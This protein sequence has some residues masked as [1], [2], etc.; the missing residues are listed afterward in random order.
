[1]GTSFLGISTPTGATCEKF[2]CENVGSIHACDGDGRLHGHGMVHV[3][4]N[5]LA[6]LCDEHARAAAD[7]WKAKKSGKVVDKFALKK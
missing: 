5:T 1:M 6:W 4:G 2:G 3:N 7:W